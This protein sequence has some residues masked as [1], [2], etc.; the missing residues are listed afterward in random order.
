[1][2]SLVFNV[3]EAIIRLAMFVG[4]LSAISLWGQYKRVLMYHGAEHK[5]INAH[6]AGV[7]MDVEHVKHYSRL[8]PRCGTSLLIHSANNQY[9]FIHHNAYDNAQ[10]GFR[11]KPSLPYAANPGYRRNLL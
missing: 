11:Y 5:A 6:E 7:P 3:A 8:H 4:Y 9:R 1:M 10:N 2:G